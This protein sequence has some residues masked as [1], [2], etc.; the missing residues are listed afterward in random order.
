MN[1]RV[2]GGRVDE[3]VSGCTSCSYFAELRCR[4]KTAIER[5][6]QPEMLLLGKK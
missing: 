6:I 1:G 4:E 5:V 2:A 3:W